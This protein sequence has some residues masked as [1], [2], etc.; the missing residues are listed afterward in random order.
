MKTLITLILVLFMSAL[1]AQE[2]T[3][4]TYLAFKN[5]NVSALKS[6]IAGQDV[7]S[8]LDVKDSAYTLLGL[9]I[10]MEATASLDYLIAQKGIDLDKACTGKTPLL[11][12]AKYGHLDMM[13]SLLAA[14][15]D[16][17]ITNKGRTLL[18][19]AKKYKQ[20]EIVDFL[21]KA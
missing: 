6:Q 19:Y 7:N 12:T 20:Q 5:D 16:P 2:L 11:Y 1:H 9:A 10:K 21:L 15:A 4:D 14:G 3:K 13:K 18:D 17:K 8:C